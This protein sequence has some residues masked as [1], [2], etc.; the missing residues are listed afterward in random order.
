MNARWVFLLLAAFGCAQPEASDTAEPAESTESDLTTNGRG[1]VAT[2]G[3]YWLNQSNVARE[4]DLAGAANVPGVLTSAHS[5]SPYMHAAT[6]ELV[7]WTN[8]SADN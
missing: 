6:I 3:G 5:T 1:I 8:V 2:G 7:A 4:L